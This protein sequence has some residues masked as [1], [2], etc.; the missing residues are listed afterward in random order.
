MLACETRLRPAEVF[1]DTGRHPWAFAFAHAS[2]N[3]DGSC[4]IIPGAGDVGQTIKSAG[5]IGLPDGKIFVGMCANV[6][7]D[8]TVVGRVVQLKIKPQLNILWLARQ[9][10]V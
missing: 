10:Y 8:L 2:Q 6:A 5:Q 3:T 4:T 7:P 9:R 1:N